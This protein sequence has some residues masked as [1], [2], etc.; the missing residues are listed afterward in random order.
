MRA[1]KEAYDVF[2]LYGVGAHETYVKALEM[3]RQR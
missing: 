1:M 3:V 2:G